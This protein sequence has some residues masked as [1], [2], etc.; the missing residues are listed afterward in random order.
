MRRALVFASA[1]ALLAAAPPSRACAAEPA[2]VQVIIDASGSMAGQVGGRSKLD[3]AKEVLLGLVNDLPADA[4]IGV[5]A[6]GHRKKDDCADIERLTTLGPRDAAQIERQVK[7]LRPVGMTPITAALETA[8][9]DFSSQPGR[10]NVVILV[11]DGVETCKGDPCAAAK[12]LRAAGADVQVNVIGFDVKA[13]ERKQLECIAAGGGGRYYNAA[14]AKEFQV[15]AAEVK[16]QIAQAPAPA[17]AGGG[18]FLDNFDGA[19]L[20]PA[21][22]ILKED[23]NRWALDGGKLTIV[24]QKGSIWQKNDT[25][26]NQFVLERSLPANYVVTAKVAMTLRSQNQWTGMLL[27][28]DADNYLEVGYWGKPWGS[29]VWRKAVFAKEL[30]GQTN[31]LEFEPREIGG[32]PGVPK[33]DFMGPTKDPE[34]VWLRVEK[35]GNTFSASFSMDGRNWHKIGDHTMLR[36]SGA[37]LSLMASNETSGDSAEVAAEFDF[38]EIQPQP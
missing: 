34:N 15:A 28:L 19:K 36:M 13:D 21:W 11:S 26:R 20:N 1:V 5:L 10:R 37:K 27:Y 22:K 25:L 24:T 33:L 23:K 9:A 8:G 3:V 38:V 2:N 16:Q 12:K 17:P 31:V 30:E 32:Q 4:N 18:G 14:T 7:A 29:N 6:Y 35:K